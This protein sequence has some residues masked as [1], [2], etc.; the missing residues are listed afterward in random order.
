MYSL[1]NLRPTG[2]EPEF[3]RFYG[4][5]KAFPVTLLQ[6]KLSFG[7]LFRIRNAS[8]LHNIL[9]LKPKIDSFQEKGNILNY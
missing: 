7:R 1:Q 2:L 4:A 3:S 9:K 6:A 8:T 5:S